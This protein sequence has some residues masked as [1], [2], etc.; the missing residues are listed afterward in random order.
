MQHVATKGI[1]Y[2]RIL[3]FEK[4]AIEVQDKEFENRNNQVQYNYL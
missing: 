4:Y 3:G 2:Y 1:K